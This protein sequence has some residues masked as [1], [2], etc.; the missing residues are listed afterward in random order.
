LPIGC[1]GKNVSFP[2]RP[3]RERSK[4]GF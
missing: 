3:F 2:T 4:E 1:T